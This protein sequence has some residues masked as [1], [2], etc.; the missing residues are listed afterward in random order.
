MTTTAPSVADRERERVIAADVR[1]DPVT[2]R[3]VRLRAGLTQDEIAERVGVT[4]YAICAYER[5]R[6]HPSL[7]NAVA[8]QR[9]LD[10]LIEARNG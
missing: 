9:V 5:G 8:Y 7:I 1:I 4:R 10:E 3:A 6:R 2:A